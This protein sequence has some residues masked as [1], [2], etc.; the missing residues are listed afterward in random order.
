MVEPLKCGI[1]EVMDI[2]KNTHT[3]TQAQQQ[4]ECKMQ[5]LVEKVMLTSI[6]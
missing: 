5:K 3:H 1:D 2:H 4:T 6:S